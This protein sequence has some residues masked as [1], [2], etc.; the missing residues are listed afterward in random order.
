MKLTIEKLIYGGYGLARTDEKVVFVKDGVPGDQLEVKITEEKKSFVVAEINKII[1]P[2]KY[3][4][5]PECEY[6]GKCGGCQWQHIDYEYQL[7]SKEE[8]LRESLERIAGIKEVSVEPIVPSDN[9]YNY[10]NRVTLHQD[11]IKGKQILGFKEEKSHILVPI[12]NCPISSNALNK[13]INRISNLLIGY[14]AHTSPFEKIYISNRDKIPGLSIT[15]KKNIP[16]SE[17]KKLF[18]KLKEHLQ[19]V[20]IS[21]DNKEEKSFEFKVLGLKFI[22]SPSV[23]AQANS[24]VNEKLIKTLIKWSDLKKYENVLDL[25]C[26]YGNLS[27]PMA[28]KAKKVVGIDSNRKAIRFA[29]QNAKINSIKNCSFESQ[30]VKQYLENLK[31]NERF[32]SVVLDPPRT[33]VKEII[34]SIIGLK[35]SKI[36][37]VSCNPTTLAR[38]LKELI[39]AGYNLKKIQ[40]FDMFPQTFHIESVSLLEI[41]KSI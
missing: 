37:Y 2:S 32:D 12:E 27:L 33:G 5:V 14:K 36:L 31:S 3:R 9:K 21:F 18:Y 10:R 7:R 11:T 6:F 34:K 1:K 20:D 23:F 30:D 28:K 25:Y 22:S 41:I 24:D 38:D 39:K 16:E 4:V 40:P 35:P 17:V 15:P 13:V 26:G 29:K 19:G 8:I